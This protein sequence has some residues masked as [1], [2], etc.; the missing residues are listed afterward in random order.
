MP[1]LPPGDLPPGDLPDPGIQP[2]F[3]AAPALA[4]RFFSAEP[5]GKPLWA[6]SNY[7]SNTSLGRGRNYF[8]NT[9]ANLKNKWQRNMPGRSLFISVVEEREEL[10]LSRDCKRAF[11]WSFPWWD[12][13]S[14][15]KIVGILRQ[16]V[17]FGSNSRPN[18]EVGGGMG[19]RGTAS[20][21]PW[22]LSEGKKEPRC[23][24]SQSREGKRNY[25]SALLPKQ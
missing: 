16:I 25:A 19:R 4:G 1:C 7:H 3:P 14:D 15:N 21:S 23:R 24:P 5:P 17:P 18:S 6:L 10:V 13:C 2:K 11:F 8:V 22:G 9:G 20:S 12:E